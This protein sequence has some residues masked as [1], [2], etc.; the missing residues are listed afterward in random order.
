MFTHNPNALICCEILW[1]TSPFEQIIL[2]I[3]FDSLVLFIGMDLN[4]HGIALVVKHVCFTFARSANSV[5]GRLPSLNGAA[6]IQQTIPWFLKCKLG[7]KL[8]C[9]VAVWQNALLLS[10]ER[11]YTV[12]K[13]RCTVRIFRPIIS[14]G[15]SLGINRVLIFTGVKP[16]EPK[17]SFTL[18]QAGYQE[19]PEK[20]G[21]SHPLT[22]PPMISHSQ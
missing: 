19:W 15:P 10:Q 20:Q 13:S 12:S 8:Y 1:H 4:E 3:L 11:H 9:P 17:F 5:R 18:L 16:T 22:I 14:E 7:S 6:M 2:L 21:M